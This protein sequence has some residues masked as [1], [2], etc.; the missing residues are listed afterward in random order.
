VITAGGKKKEKGGVQSEGVCL[1]KEPFHRMSPA[2]LEVAEPL[3]AY[4]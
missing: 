1:P 4:G 3:P 2:L